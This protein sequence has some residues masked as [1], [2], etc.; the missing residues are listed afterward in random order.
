VL[1]RSMDESDVA[2]IGTIERRLFRKTYV[3]EQLGKWCGH[4]LVK[5]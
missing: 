3:S 4:S 2:M 5:N 1:T